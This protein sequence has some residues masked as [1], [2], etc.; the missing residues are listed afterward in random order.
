MRQYLFVLTFCSLLLPLATGA[1]AQGLDLPV[2]RP[3]TTCA[4][5]VE[6][7]LVPIGGAGSAVT[8]AQETTSGGLPVCAVSGRLAPA[9]Q[10]QVV[11]P[12]Q[13]WTQRYLQL[14]CGGLCGNITLRSGASDGCAILQEG[15]FVM[16]A[17]DM[18]H[19]GPDEAWMANAQQR[20]DF[21]WRAQHLTAAA[22]RQLIQQFYGQAER[23]SYFNGCSDGGRE[24]LMA[25]QRFPDDFDGIIAGAPAL[26][27]T[28]QNTLYHG[29]IAAANRAADGQT[30]LT[31]E[32]LPILHSAVVAA[33][34]KVD[35]VQD[36]LVSNPAACHFDPA[37][38]VCAAEDDPS[39]CLTA[40][41]AEVAAKIYLGPHDPRSG[42]A[43]TAGQPLY[44]S[45]LEWQ[46]VQ[47]SDTPERAPMSRMIATPVLKGLAFDPP[48]PELTPETIAFDTATL[49]ALRPRSALFNASNTDLAPFAAS[50]GKLIL[51]HGLADQHISPANTV[52]YM[53][54]LRRDMGA[55]AAE[56]FTRLY[57]LPGVGHCSGGRGPSKIDLLSAMLD[58]VET[59]AAPDGVMTSSTA[60]SSSFGQPDGIKEAGHVMGAK[61]DLGVPPLPAMSRPVY[62]WPHVA[63][64]NG[65]GDWTDGANWI[66]GPETHIVPTRDW[67]GANLFGPYDF[68]D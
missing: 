46:G 28:V 33:C 56:A 12:L 34:D 61:L 24:A 62:P 14:G 38:L 51:W 30:I 55:E 20:S 63:I 50:G 27:F 16:A 36:G 31:S 60:E 23:F 8:A 68:A 7:D 3:V 1:Q 65:A 67:P 47:V 29:W 48:R 6:T 39:T 49:E 10:F 18:G 19:E 41:E 21:A 59:G 22:A 13:G 15:G 35:G 17:T 9:I 4:A 40:A 42:A 58:W 25:A 11:L 2:V 45:E 53:E 44:G 43:L 5:L 64:W 37:R 54:A 32:K 66:K 52:A 57:L 26:L